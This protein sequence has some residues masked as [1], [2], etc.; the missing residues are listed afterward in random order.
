VI[1]DLEQGV[2]QAAIRRACSTGYSVTSWTFPGKR[3]H[4]YNHVSD[5]GQTPPRDGARLKLSKL[6]NKDVSFCWDVDACQ[7]AE[8]RFG[9]ALFA[10]FPA[11]KHGTRFRGYRY[12]NE[13]SAGAQGA[14]L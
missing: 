11:G 12:G 14:V 2:V 8:I 6:L 5:V 4:V 9:R 3:P 10:R 7:C 1:R 13:P